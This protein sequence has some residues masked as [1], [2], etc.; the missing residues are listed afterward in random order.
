M[1]AQAML[2]AARAGG[3][4]S[5]FAGSSV[6]PSLVNATGVPAEQ[7]RIFLAQAQAR[8]LNAAELQ[9][10]REDEF[11][12]RRWNQGIQVRR[13]P[14]VSLASLGPVHGI[15]IGTAF[16]QI[17]GGATSLYANQN[18]GLLPS[19][20]NASSILTSANAA[21]I[22]QVQR[23]LQQMDR[24]ALLL[25]E[26]RA[27][28]G[29][30]TLDYIHPRTMLALPATASG[31]TGLAVLQG[32]HLQTQAS[33]FESREALGRAELPVFTSGA[34]DSNS[35]VL[36]YSHVGI[37]EVAQ[38]E[39]RVS[40]HQGKKRKKK[41]HSHR[42]ETRTKVRK[43]TSSIRPEAIRSAESPC[44]ELCD[45]RHASALRMDAE[46][47]APVAAQIQMTANS[48]ASVAK[49]SSSASASST[50]ASDVDD[51]CEEQD[52]MYPPSRSDDGEAP[53]RPMSAFLAFSNKR[54]KSLKR[55][56]PCASNADLSKMLAKT[57]HEAPEAIRE[58]Y[59]NEAAALSE[60]YK[61][62]ISK[63][64]KRKK[65]G[66]HDEI[67]S[68]LSTANT[69]ALN[70]EN[71][72]NGEGSMKRDIADCDDSNLEQNFSLVE[73]NSGIGRTI[74]DQI[75][76]LFEKN[77]WDALT[78][79]TRVIDLVRIYDWSEV[80]TAMFECY[81]KCRTREK[82]DLTQLINRAEALG[83][84]RSKIPA[85]NMDGYRQEL[86]DDFV[87]TLE[88][89]L[90]DDKATDYDHSAD[91]AFHTLEN[92][93]I[94]VRLL[95]ELGSRNDFRRIEELASKAP[96]EKLSSLNAL[97][98]TVSPSVALS[99]SR[100]MD[101][102]E[103][104]VKTVGIRFKAFKIDD[105]KKQ[106]EDLIE[107]TQGCEPRFS[108]SMPKADTESH[109]LNAFLRCS[110]KGPETIVVDGGKDFARELAR[111][112]K[113]DAEH[114]NSHGRM[115]KAGFSAIIQYTDEPEDK[116]AVT[117]TKTKDLHSAEVLQYRKD[118]VKLRNVCVE[119]RNLGVQ[120]VLLGTAEAKPVVMNNDEGKPETSP[121]LLR[122]QI[123][124]REWRRG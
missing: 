38:A 101:A 61:A 120:A 39:R 119:L 105:L 124:K 82:F 21:C 77:S 8:A 54:R 18:L 31:S 25:E 6:T 106:R 67:D 103:Q 76:A 55:Q 1:D 3:N 104:C 75:F 80:E 22:Q 42:G 10:D 107:A 47:A 91:P 43:Y 99:D 108:W 121:P 26:E 7:Q 9:R 50:D 58:K 51:G 48:K 100:D 102:R 69:G 111:K 15:P 86:V 44:H 52:D 60:Q 74:A 112:Y 73:G 57:W 115:L 84:L 70:E 123:S 37:Q 30:R 98:E 35:D 85:V 19:T 81:G 71:Q 116:A 5:F 110:R 68:S 33:R 28:Q 56:Y 24:N 12:L 114:R 94:V 92:I 11:L 87:K 88:V 89:V 95:L 97:F 93:E 14:V 72:T 53:K 113:C 20:L 34:S 23:E 117:V 27:R 90:L 79:T 46:R 36:A 109:A 78:L 59:I 40:S 65:K 66:D 63:W 32:L 64:R 83:T 122:S 118:M 29:L 45:T 96:L 2:A 41:M 4:L 13:D 62:D 49:A 16:A 17:P